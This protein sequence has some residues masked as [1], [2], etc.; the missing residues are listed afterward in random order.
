MM[1]DEDV[2][3]EH[4]LVM[5]LEKFQDLVYKLYEDEQLDV[6]VLYDGR[7]LLVSDE[8]GNSG[9]VLKKIEKHFG[10][11]IKDIHVDP[12]SADLDVYISY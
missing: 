4:S 6:D 5:N 11:K 7:R 12:N 3:L 8:H 2:R 10:I 9:P 1:R